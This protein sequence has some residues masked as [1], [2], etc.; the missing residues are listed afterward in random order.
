MILLWP[1]KISYHKLLFV[2]QF[3]GKGQILGFLGIQ[4]TFTPS[5]TDFSR[6]K[7]VI[8][9]LC[10]LKPQLI[11]NVFFILEGVKCSL[12]IGNSIFH[13]NPPFIFPGELDDAQ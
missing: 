8:Y 7:M 9:Q 5:F 10:K 13:F 1:T 6:C 4:L 12:F 2:L 11:V 3:K